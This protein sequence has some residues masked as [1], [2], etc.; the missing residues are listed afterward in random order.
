MTN[1]INCGALVFIAGIILIQR[2]V[3]G[4]LLVN[5]HHGLALACL[6]ILASAVRLLWAGL[7]ETIQD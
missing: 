6:V 1:L 7:D 2:G 4:S 3:D 5:G